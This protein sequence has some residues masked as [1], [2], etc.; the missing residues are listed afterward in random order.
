MY[1]T[2]CHKTHLHPRTQGPVPCRPS[3]ILCA[4]MALGL[5]VFS[6]S[7]QA[8]STK[9]AAE[10]VVSAPA[11]KKGSVKV[12]HQR[13]PSEESTAERDRRLYRECKGLPNAGACLG[14]TRR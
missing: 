13:S 3:A 5:L 7:A 14:Y 12:K 8:A 9:N 1:I 11:K 2:H 10:T 4:C 6:N